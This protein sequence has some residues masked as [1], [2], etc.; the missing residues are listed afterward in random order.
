MSDKINYGLFNDK[1][2]KFYKVDTMYGIP[3]IKELL[4]PAVKQLLE[5]MERNPGS[6]LEHNSLLNFGR[7]SL[8]DGTS[9]QVKQEYNLTI[10]TFLELKEAHISDAIDGMH[11]YKLH[12]K[13]MEY[14]RS[15]YQNI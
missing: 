7:L 10:L 5:I 8:G 15:H 14:I 3:I 1:E 11:H 2:F 12:P 9:M 13:A 6:C 4:S